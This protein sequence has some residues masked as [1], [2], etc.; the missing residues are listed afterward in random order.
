MRC[1]DCPGRHFEVF[2]AASFLV[3]VALLC[4]ADLA[5]SPDYAELSSRIPE[6]APYFLALLLSITSSMQF[7]SLFRQ[8]CGARL[9]CVY[10]SLPFWSFLIYYYLAWTGEIERAAHCTLMLGAQIYAASLLLVH[11]RDRKRIDQGGMA[12]DH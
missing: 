4:L 11:I 8:D 7:S 2:N 6:T 10:C 12:Y 1:Q 3:N 9:F 5:W